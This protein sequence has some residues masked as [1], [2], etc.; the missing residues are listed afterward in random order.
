VTEPA[1]ATP[2]PT[3]QVLQAVQRLRPAD[4]VNEPGMQAVHAR[5]AEIVA[6]ELVNVPTMH[7][8]LTATQGSTP[9][10]AE[11]VVPGMHAVHCRSELVDPSAET[12]NPIP[13]VLH[14][15]HALRPS[16]EVNEP[17]GQ[18]AHVRSE[19]DVATE[20]AYKPARHG[21]LTASHAWAFAVV[22]KV[23]PS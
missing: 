13:Q 1:A 9:F 4:D 20:V 22:E 17:L 2:K 18:S 8:G 5:S 21:A 16:L 15:A 6:V 12:P 14:A 23:V 7:A 19:D 11:K 3:P 10:V